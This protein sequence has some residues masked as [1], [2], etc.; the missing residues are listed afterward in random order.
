MDDGLKLLIYFLVGGS[1]LTL[2]TYFG[3]KDKGILA[4]FIA[5]FPAVTTM[6]IITIYSE[7]GG[8]LVLDYVK[9]LL[10]LSPVWM[11]FLLCVYFFLPKQGLLVALGAGIMV[12]ILVAV[13]LF[14]IQP[15][16]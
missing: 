4:A 8:L 15:T 12:Y 9:G 7:A 10:L 5:M 6:S 11:V 16:I 3:S 2:V 1:I 13:F 14:Y